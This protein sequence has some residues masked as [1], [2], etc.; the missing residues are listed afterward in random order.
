MVPVSYITYLLCAYL[1]YRAQIEVVLEELAQKLST[2]Y[3]E[4]SL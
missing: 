4:A 2:L 3:V 1:A